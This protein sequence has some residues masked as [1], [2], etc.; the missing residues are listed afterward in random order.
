[1][2]IARPLLLVT[3]PVGVIW[4]LVEAARFHWWLAL[5]MGLLMSVI[6][7]FAALTVRRIR[8]DRAAQYSRA[9]SVTDKSR[10]PAA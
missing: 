8:Q 2:R 3:T 4:G 9:G 7:A 10:S 1:M 6:A 5:L